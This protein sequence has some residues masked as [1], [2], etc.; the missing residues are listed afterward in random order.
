LILFI[1]EGAK[2]A[3]ISSKHSVLKTII[4]IVVWAD[5]IIFIKEEG[6]QM[7]RI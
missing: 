4:E 3:K 7:T 2:D 5:G 6:T 1:A